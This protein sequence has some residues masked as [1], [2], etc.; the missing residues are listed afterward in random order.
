MRIAERI[1]TT[2]AA[3]LL[4]AVVPTLTGAPMQDRIV[5]ADN[6]SKQV[7]DSQTIKIIETEENG[8]TTIHA[9]V[10]GK[11]VDPKD[12]PDNIKVMI[13]DHGGQQIYFSGDDDQDMPQHM[14]MMDHPKVMIGITMDEI[15]PA[16]ASQ[17]NLHPEA[18]TMIS[19]VMPDLPGDK[20]GLQPY[21]IIV[22]ADGQKPMGRE[23]LLDL[24][25]EKSPGDSLHLKV[26]R[27]GK[28]IGID[29]V[30][31]PWDPDVMGE[32]ENQMQMFDEDGNFGMN[33]PMMPGRRMQREMKIRIPELTDELAEKLRRAMEREQNVIIEKLERRKNA[34]DDAHHLLRL[35]ASVKDL[36]DDNEAAENDDYLQKR[37]N[38]LEDRLDRIEELLEHIA[39]NKN[40]G[41]HDHDED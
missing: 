22:A 40:H 3:A 21:D 32:F 34:D 35:R 33:M 8:K 27:H 10:N 13:D 30:L 15:S 18:V 25:H 14:P 29:V 16:L 39:K 11:E 24:L 1:F 5:K 38:R 20:A 17:L 37:M 7:T 2:A 12:L 19:E 28:P 36:D 4:F 23:D 31:E 9:Y 6:D 41:D 26:I